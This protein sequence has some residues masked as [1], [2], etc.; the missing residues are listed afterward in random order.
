ML[1]NI[2]QPEFVKRIRTR[3]DW[4]ESWDPALIDE[5]TVHDLDKAIRQFTANVERAIIDARRRK[6]RTDQE[7]AR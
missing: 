2:D 6:E 4:I 3:A 1:K 7:T 5:L